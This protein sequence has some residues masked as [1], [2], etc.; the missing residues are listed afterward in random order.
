MLLAFLH[1]PSGRIWIVLAVHIV[2]IDRIIGGIRT[3]IAKKVLPSHRVV[4]FGILDDSTVEMKI[5]ITEI[6]LFPSRF[7]NNRCKR[8]ILP[9]L[10]TF[11]SCKPGQFIYLRV[12]SV[13]HLQW[14]PFSIANT[15]DE[16]ELQLVYKEI[17]G[18]HKSSQ[19]SQPASERG[20]KGPH[21]A[22]NTISWT[23]WWPY[24]IT[25]YS[26]SVLFISGGSESSFT[27][28]LALDLVTQLNK[29]YS[30]THYF[31]SP[32]KF[33]VKLVSYVLRE[34]D[35]SWYS[36]SLENNHTCLVIVEKDNS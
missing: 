20:R 28:P 22:R 24:P 21:R 34:A 4:K 25:H 27:I 8:Y 32:E 18:I 23:V 29:K 1:N 33:Q 7:E 26:A 15:S 12:G 9:C 36:E 2:V 19:P 11:G 35:I 13:R 3:F 30:A 6:Y 31:G 16:G 10:P 14:H 5:E 17:H